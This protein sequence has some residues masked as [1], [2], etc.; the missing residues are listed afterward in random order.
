MKLTPQAPSDIVDAMKATSASAEK[1]GVADMTLD[2]IN[3]EI[4][5]V[6]SKR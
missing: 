4:A 5:L 6:R 1:A 2:E 3:A